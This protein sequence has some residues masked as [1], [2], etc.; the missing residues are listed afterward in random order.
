MIHTIAG[1]TSTPPPLLRRKLVE[2]DLD[3]LPDLEA[4]ANAFA[5]FERRE[6]HLRQ[7]SLV[8]TLRCRDTMMQ[9]ELA[10]KQSVDAFHVNKKATE[11][12]SAGANGRSVKKSVKMTKKMD[13]TGDE[14]SATMDETLN[15]REGIRNCLKTV[16]E[17][18]AGLCPNDCPVAEEEEEEEDPRMR[19]REREIQRVREQ[20]DAE[21]TQAK[22]DLLPLV[23]TTTCER[24]NADI[25]KRNKGRPDTRGTRKDEQ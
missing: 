24:E 18:T 6:R 10:Q 8:S 7:E 9:V 19:V 15:V 12:L 20:H 13:K 2:L 14:M 4:R 17:M 25:E 11:M 1:C 22:L 21:I 3:I 5:L 16:S 23:P